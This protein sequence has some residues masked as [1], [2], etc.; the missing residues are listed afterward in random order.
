MRGIDGKQAGVSV[1]RAH[2]VKFDTWIQRVTGVPMEPRAAVAEWADGKLTVWTGTQRPFGVRSELAAA[3]R[4]PEDRVRV[5]VPDAGS[6]YGGKH[7]GEHAVEAARLARA[8]GK[9]VKLVWTRREEFSYGY[10]RPAGVID[11]KA[12]VDGEGRLTLWEF[13]NW[14]S[15]GSAIRTPYEV[16][17]QRI[18]FHASDSPLRITSSPRMTVMCSKVSPACACA[19]SRQPGSSVSS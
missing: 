14:N 11:I 9:P 6:A 10:F 5:I 16:A 18:Q 3:F 2:V 7:S 15:G 13:D 17:N 1:H 8:A 19:S 4:V 12:G